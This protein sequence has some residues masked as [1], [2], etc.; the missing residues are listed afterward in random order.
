[1]VRP[2]R[3]LTLTNRALRR[4]RRFLV[5][6]NRALRRTSRAFGSTKRVLHRT[7]R[8]L[9]WT[10]RVLAERNALASTTRSQERTSL[11]QDRANVSSER[12]G[13][14]S[15]ETCFEKCKRRFRSRLSRFSRNQESLFETTKPIFP[16]NDRAFPDH[17]H[18]RR[19]IMSTHDEIHPPLD[20]FPS[21]PGE[22][23]GAHH[24][25]P[26]HREGDDRKP[27]LPESHAHA[28]RRH[29]GHR[30]AADR[31]DG[32]AGAHQGRRHHTQRQARRR[33]SSLLQQVRG[34]IQAVAD[35]D[36]TN[37][38]AIIQ[39]AGVAVRKVPTRQARAFAA[40]PGAVSGVAKIV[41][42]AGGPARVVRMAVQHRRRQDLA[43]GAGHAAGQDDRLGPDAGRDGAVQVPAGDQGRRRRLEPAGRAPRGVAKRVGVRGSSRLG[44]RPR[45]VA[46][47]VARVVGG[48]LILRKLR[49]TADERPPARRSLPG[50]A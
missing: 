8:A 40:K 36:L 30:R 13:F 22:R 23:A 26:G 5:S 45:R 10:K 32:G 7:R 34:H 35:A 16:Y 4:P 43:D 33:S 15:N 39:S 28:R 37:A 31:R 20:G 14:E 41:A 25:C 9:S 46:A 2:S 3:A 18:Q 47:G 27:V 49:T 19:V 11:S 21:S 17:H 44:R 6:T 29:G 24:V 50:R 12:K 38:A 48:W 42:E 1:M